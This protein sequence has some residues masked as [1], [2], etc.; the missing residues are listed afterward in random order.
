MYAALFAFQAPAAAS[1]FPAASPWVVMLTAS[2]EEDA[3]I[4]AVAAGAT[5]YLFR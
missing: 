4:E 1:R 3:V 5:G 2:T